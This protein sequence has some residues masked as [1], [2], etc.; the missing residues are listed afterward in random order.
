MLVMSTP[1]VPKYKH[2]WTLTRSL[3]CYFDP[4]ISIEYFLNKKNCIL[5]SLFNDK[6]NNINFT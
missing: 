6:S 2:F 4:T 1:S 3:R 5:D